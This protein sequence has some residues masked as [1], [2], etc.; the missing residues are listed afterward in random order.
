MRSLTAKRTHCRLCVEVAGRSPER[1]YGKRQG[2][3]GWTPANRA[4]TAVELVG[5]S[6]KSECTRESE[7]P[8]ACLAVFHTGG[9]DGETDSARRRCVP[10]PSAIAPVRYHVSY[11]VWPTEARFGGHAKH[12]E[13]TWRRRLGLLASC[14]GESAADHAAL[15]ATEC[16]RARTKPGLNRDSSLRSV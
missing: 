15:G 6:N 3:V 13:Y 4:P 11:C 12:S 8:G 14:A 7:M 10:Q 16:H 9:A 2:C 5:T 1:R